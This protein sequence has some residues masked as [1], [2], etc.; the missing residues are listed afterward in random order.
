MSAEVSPSKLLRIQ[1]P[2]GLDIPIAGAP[3]QSIVDGPNVQSVGLVADD[4]IGMKPTMAVQEGDHVKAGQLLFEDKKTLGVRYTAPAAGRVTA[5][6]RGEKRKFQSLVIEIDG[7]A[8]ESFEKYDDHFLYNLERDKVRVNLLSSGLWTALRARPYGK[9]PPPESVPHS[10]FVNA[11]DTNP[12]AAKPSVVLQQYDYDR[13]FVAGL[14]ALSTLTD[15]SLYLCKPQG[16]EIPGLDEKCVQVAQF[17]GPHPAGLPGTHIHFLDPVN[18]TK[19]VW[20][21]GYQDV[22]AV[23]HLF[24]T[25]KLLTSRTISLAGPAVDQPRLIRSRIGASIPELTKDAYDENSDVRIISGSVLS[26][27]QSVEPTD[28][29]GRYH[30]QISILGEGR[31]RELMGWSVPGVRKFSITRAFASAF[32]QIPKLPFTTTTNGSVRAIIPIGMY[33]KVMPLDILPTPLLKSL[34]VQDT[35]TAQM[36][37]CL[38]LEEE[39]L[40]LCTFACPGKNDYGTL[41][42]TCLTHIEAEG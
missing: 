23:G 37:G 35:E 5:I 39:D 9:V 25:G 41:L 34:L 19:T 20:H 3:K 10:L 30:N 29:L 24:L 31:E 11:M 36:L 40:A 26:G 6:N 4:Y 17:E 32:T 21:I 22:V 7:D 33:E 16:A 14:Q 18:E 2:K 8:E 42:R 27:R 12:L 1:V 28:Y 38:E 13:W 15:G